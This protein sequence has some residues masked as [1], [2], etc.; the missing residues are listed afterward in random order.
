[1]DKMLKRVKVDNNFFLELFSD[2]DVLVHEYFEN[3]W[4]DYWMTCDEVESIFKI[5]L[6]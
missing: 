2:G 4:F 5:K 1:M 3:E 6:I